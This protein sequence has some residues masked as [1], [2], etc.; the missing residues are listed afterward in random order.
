LILRAFD[1]GFAVASNVNH[2]LIDHLLAVPIGAFGARRHGETKRALAGSVPEL[3]AAFVNL[4]GQIG[5]ALT[6]PFFIGIGLLF[7]AWPLGVVTLAAAPLLISA[8]LLG[9][10]L[11]RNAE[12]AYAAASDEAAE[13]TDEFARAQLVLRAAGRTGVE[14]TPLGDAID[15]Q[16]RT[17]LG[18]LWRSVPGTLVFSIAFQLVLI[19]MVA[20]IVWQFALSGLEAAEA[21]ALIVVVT[22]YLEPFTVLSDLFPAVESVR[23]A[24]RRTLDV[25]GLPV[26]K[27]AMADAAPKAPDVEF[28]NVGFAPGGTRVLE[29]ISFTVPSGTTTAIVGPSGSGK[30]TILSLVAR[31]HEVDV[32]RVLVS[33]NDVRDYR[34]ATLMDQLAIVF[35][36]VQLFEGGIADNIRLARPS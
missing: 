17:G 10:R 5:I 36:N 27:P 18:M 24:W 4:G 32:G 11:M 8:L 14:G 30:S 9:A 21:V 3:F 13:R 12:A 15:R 2:R 31:F 16:R 19:A 33:G 34:A 1:L 26:L 22:R 28:R 7:V 6:L 20:T 35:Q 25:F 29:N 23:G